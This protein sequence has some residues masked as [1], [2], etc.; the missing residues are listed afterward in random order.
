MQ[1]TISKILTSK[2]QIYNKLSVVRLIDRKIKSGAVFYLITAITET[3]M[4][5]RLPFLFHM[6]VTNSYFIV[7]VSLE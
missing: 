4:P 2:D 6:H 3:I 5:I 7:R 1:K